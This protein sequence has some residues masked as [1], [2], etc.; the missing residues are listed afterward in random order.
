[1]EYCDFL[2]CFKRTQL[3]DSSGAQSAHW[4]NVV[5]RPISSAWQFS[6]ISCELLLVSQVLFYL[7]SDVNRT[8]KS[9]HHPPH[10]PSANI[11]CGALN[12]RF[13]RPKCLR[14]P[15]FAFLKLTAHY[16]DQ[17]H[18]KCASDS[19]DGGCPQRS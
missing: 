7:N 19:S 18:N 14:L 16:I 11:K 4:L 1:M 9:P 13:C 5:C 17:S 12:F 10:R 2:E 3:F 6:N 8:Y 15:P